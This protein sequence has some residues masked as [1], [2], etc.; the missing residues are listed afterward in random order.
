M[1][2]VLGAALQTPLRARLALSTL[3]ED[4]STAVIV[5]CCSFELV[6]GAV[7]V[8]EVGEIFAL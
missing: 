5:I 3:L 2:A 8:L 4:G 6:V 1:F 7:S